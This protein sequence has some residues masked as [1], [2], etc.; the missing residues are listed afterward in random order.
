MPCVDFPS[1]DPNVHASANLESVV[2]NQSMRTSVRNYD[3]AGCQGNPRSLTETHAT[4]VVQ[5]SYGGA[6]LVAVDLTERQ[7]LRTYYGIAATQAGQDA[8]CGIR[9]W[10]S[11]ES[12]DVTRADCSA[13][14][15]IDQVQYGTYKI[16]NGELFVSNSSLVQT[17]A[18]GGVLPGSTPETRVTAFDSIGW[19]RT[20]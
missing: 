16:V 13:D 4:F 9:N 3:S 8:E 14:D 2:R 15:R 5:G 18:G 12:R 11:A 17:P 19:K 6:D 20:R 7:V 1:A 10:R